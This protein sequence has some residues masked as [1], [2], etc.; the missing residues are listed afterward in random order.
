MNTRFETMEKHIKSLTDLVGSLIDDNNK[1]ISM[2]TGYKLAAHTSQNENAKVFQ[3][4]VKFFPR[5]TTKCKAKYFI[6][7]LL[8]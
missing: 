4:S 3:V 7:C 8:K 2:T 1:H 6:S 5:E